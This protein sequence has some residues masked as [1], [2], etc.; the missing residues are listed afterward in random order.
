MLIKFSIKYV[1][2]RIGTYITASIYFTHSFHKQLLISV[3]RN[4]VFKLNHD[5]IFINT[6]IFFYKNKQ[7]ERF[8]TSFRIV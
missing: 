8:G 6:T 4:V 2:C 3:H 7:D 1:H 5:P